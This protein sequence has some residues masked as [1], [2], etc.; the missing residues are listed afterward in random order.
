LMSLT[1]IIVLLTSA[2][3]SGAFFF[4]FCFPL[5]I[6]LLC[7]YLVMFSNQLL[8]HVKG[9]NYGGVYPTPLIDTLLLY[10][11]SFTMRIIS[12]LQDFMLYMLL[13]MK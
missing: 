3:R 6:S 8:E 2:H 1:L 5:G 11:P 13:P 7:L 12:F 9:K 4:L 10:L